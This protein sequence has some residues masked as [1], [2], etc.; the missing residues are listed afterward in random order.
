MTDDCDNSHFNHSGR[1]TFTKQK[2]K[3]DHV[4]EDADT[5]SEPLHISEWKGPLQP[6]GYKSISL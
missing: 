1:S 2:Y 5:G 4:K 6:G 3:I